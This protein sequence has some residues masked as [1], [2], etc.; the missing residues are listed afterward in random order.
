[1]DFPKTSVIGLGG[2][3]TV[4]TK[5]LH[6]QNIPVKSVFNR[7]EQR[8]TDLSAELKIEISGAFPTRLNEL[9]D[10]IFITVS[11]RSI[12]EISERLSELTGQF[13]DRTF[14]HCSGNESAD[15]LHHLQSKGAVVASFH[16]LQ[17]FTAQ[18]DPQSFKDIYFSLQ[19]DVETVPLLN[20]IADQL[21][22]HTME[23]TTDQ[24][25]H[26][27]AAAVLVSNYMTTLL[28]SAVDIGASGDLSA[29][30]VKEA[31]F[32]LAQTALK[33]T[34]SQSFE[35]ALTGPIKRGDW[36]TVDKH[37]TLLDEKP[38]LRNLYCVLGLQT[39]ELAE[40]SGKISGTSVEKLRKKLSDH[41]RL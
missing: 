18:S 12:E 19:G 15:L 27:H 22:A 8:A 9:G 34:E 20:K 6:V 28:S 16:P 11:D 26:L 32:P 4:L 5:A 37:L 10:L 30:R 40:S 17:T 21:G 33:N 25:S 3:G 38:E 31:L 24:K 14:V 36:E 35:E 41:F 39:V 1:M 29:D 2:L 7:T 13:S 23:V